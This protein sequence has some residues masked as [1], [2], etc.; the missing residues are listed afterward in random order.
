MPTQDAESE[1]FALAHAGDPQAMAP[2]IEILRHHPKRATRAAAAH[3]LEKIGDRRAISALEAA[4]NDTSDGGFFEQETPVSELAEEALLEIY[5]HVG[6]RDDDVLRLVHMLEQGGERRPYV[7]SLL[8]KLDAPMDQI[9]IAQF[10]GL[11]VLGR[12]AVLTILGQRRSLLALDL[13][14][15]SLTDPDPVI[16]DAGVEALGALGD[17]RAF[18]GVLSRLH[19]PASSVRRSAQFALRQVSDERHVPRLERILASGQF[20]GFER[21]DL[22]RALQAARERRAPEA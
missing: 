18:E 5:G 17:A 1:V 19:D 22:E 2:L 3:W 10:P 4:L 14:L 8:I 9:L 20:N 16:R 15:T 6:V 11:N 13:L 12:A 21:H 7:C